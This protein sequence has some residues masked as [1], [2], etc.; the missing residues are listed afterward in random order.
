MTVNNNMNIH[1]VRMY[2]TPA[3]PNSW[4]PIPDD[5]QNAFLARRY[6]VVTV[7]VGTLLAIFYNCSAV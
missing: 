5:V 2:R 3:R 4:G 1:Q 6:R 7:P